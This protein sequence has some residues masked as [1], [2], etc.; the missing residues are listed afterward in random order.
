LENGEIF[1]RYN[2]GVVKR[3]NLFKNKNVPFKIEV[4]KDL[5]MVYSDIPAVSITLAQW[6]SAGGSLENLPPDHVVQQ[7]A[8]ANETFTNEEGYKYTVS[9]ETEP[10]T[11]AEMEQ[12][13]L[14]F[15]KQCNVVT[16]S[17]KMS[18]GKDSFFFAI[19]NVL[20]LA[21]QLFNDNLG[22]HFLPFGSDAKSNSPRSPDHVCT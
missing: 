9:V 6:E 13:I 4:S 17:H 14:R 16:I 15:S 22:I 12:G 1:E 21:Q 20:N 3:Y 2:A 10:G 19:T 7:R 18:Q 8:F 5:P 11:L